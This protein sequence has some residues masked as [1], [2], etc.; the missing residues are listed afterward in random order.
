MAGVPGRITAVDRD[1]TGLVAA[2]WRGQLYGSES[3]V[4]WRP[5]GFRRPGIWAVSAAARAVATTD[6]LYLGAERRLVGSEV[7]GLALSGDNLFAF[8]AGGGVSVH[9]A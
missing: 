7:T 9:R 1:A 5:T 4:E 2:G 3:G 8:S 6:G